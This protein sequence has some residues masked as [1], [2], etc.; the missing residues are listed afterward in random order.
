VVLAAVNEASTPSAPRIPNLS[1]Q[2]RVDSVLE[3]SR[4]R[5]MAMISSSSDVIPASPRTQTLRANGGDRAAETESSADEETNIVRRSSKRNLNY[6]ST[7]TNATQRVG[8]GRPSTASIRRAGQVHTG[9]NTGGNEETEVDEQESWWARTLSEY[10]SIE[11]E[12][13]GSVA[14]DHLALERTFLAWLR[15]SLAFAS[16][17]VAITQLFR[18]NTSG[19]SSSDNQYIRLRQLGKPLGATFLGISIVMLSVGFHRYFE[20]QHWIVRGKFPASRGS[21]ALV[22]AVTFALMVTSLVVVIVVEP[23]AF[24]KK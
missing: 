19:P 13:K 21:I 23:G 22:A 12:N 10:G 2:E 18:L 7:N 24:E 1:Q 4:G 9:S 20:S 17:G 15:T 6:Q 3:T 14:R 8:K 11:L 5:I 16:I